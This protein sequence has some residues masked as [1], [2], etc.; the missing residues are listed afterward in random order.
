MYFHINNFADD[1]ATL[2]A[3]LEKDISNSCWRRTK[4]FMKKQVRVISIAD[5]VA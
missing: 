2:S 1:L 4:F 3:L 5:G